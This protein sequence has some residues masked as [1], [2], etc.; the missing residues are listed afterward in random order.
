MH[1]VREMRTADVADHGLPTF[2][3]THMLDLDDLGAAVTEAALGFNL[4][5]N[6]FIRRAAAAAIMEVFRLGPPP[7][8]WRSSVCQPATAIGCAPRFQ[9]WRIS[10]I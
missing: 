7:T 2:I 5:S 6:A 1:R 9:R 4:G 8:R 3:D 10:K